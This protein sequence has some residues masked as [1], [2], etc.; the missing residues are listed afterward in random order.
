[1][2]KIN[3]LTMFVGALLSLSSCTD[4]EIKNP[5]G[6]ENYS[7][8]EAQ[9]MSDYSDYTI[10]KITWSTQRNYQIGTFEI[11]PKAKNSSQS[12]TAWYAINGNS[13]K[14]EMD[15]KDLGTVIPEIIQAAFDKTKYSDATL[16]RIEEVELEHD[17]TGN[18]IVSYYEV[19]LENIAD[20]N[21]EA[22]LVFDDKTGELMHSKEETE[23][24]DKDEE[25]D[26]YIVTEGLRAA[27]E[28]AVKGAK[29]I[30]AE[31]DDNLI[32]VDAIVV[33]E[34]GLTSSE[35][36]LKFNMDYSLVSS[37]VEKE[38]TYSTMPEEFS[39]VTAWFIANSSTTPTPA[40]DTE[41]EIAYVD[42]V[43]DNFKIENYCY[44]VEIEEYDSN[45]EEYEV[46]FYLNK[47][48]VIVTVV[49]ND[50]IV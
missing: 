5:V 25:D 43:E 16:W 18:G 3:L 11:T 23:E 2:K 45:G 32:E 42:K 35:I 39:T 7:V 14:R 44:K 6:N 1:M 24:D 48:F 19:E 12:V 46:E 40:P 36:E 17:Y 34:D 4:N 15:S 31:V 27:V 29:I 10:S 21:I 37:E 13:A 28:K 47:E 20:T 8:A 22:E 9:L 33:S 49:V 30:S 26:R 50:E 41:V 38:Y